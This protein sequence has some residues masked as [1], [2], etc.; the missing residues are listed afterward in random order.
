MY[1]SM[2]VLDGHHN[3]LCNFMWAGILSDP[4]VFDAVIKRRQNE[5][6]RQIDRLIGAGI[7]QLRRFRLDRFAYGG[8]EV[9]VRSPV[10]VDQFRADEYHWKN[11]A[12]L[13][14]Q[15]NG[16]ASN[17]AYCAIDYL[18]AYWLFRYYNLDQHPVARRQR[19]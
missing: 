2:T 6:R 8:R 14:W 1:W 5:T 19:L 10:W 16:E 9:T 15:S 11:D 17:N 13:V 3:S 7:E 18:Y 12:N 4:Q